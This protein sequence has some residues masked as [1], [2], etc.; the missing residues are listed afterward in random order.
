MEPRRVRIAVG[1]APSHWGESHL[2]SL[3]H[4]LARSPADTVY[5]GETA[6]PADSSLSADFYCRICDELARA[7]KKVYASSLILVTEKDDR[8]PFDRLAHR[9]GR[10]E[11][12]SPAF[13]AAARRYHA[14]AG[15]FLNVYNAAAADIL[16]RCNVERVVLPCD[17]DIESIAAITKRCGIATEVVVHGHVPLAMSPTCLTV[18]VLGRV[19]QAFSPPEAGRPP[20]NQQPGKAAP[21]CGALCRRYP[22]GMIMNAGCRP[23][24]RI[25]GPQTLSAPAW[26]LVE[27]LPELERAGVHTI[28]ILP[29]WR[30]SGRILRI[31][32][33][34]LDRRRTPRDALN[35]LKELSPGG[36]CNGLSVGKAGWIYES[37]N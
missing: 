5:L 22:E 10:V 12:N 13:L 17:L 4:E 1:P 14:V 8:G 31:Y 26:C 16:A 23:L 35:E 6:C 30:H 33:D 19:G 20:I 37:P 9:L 25:D 27:H 3:Y 11:I 29:Q 24:F 18:R 28:R 36:L 34:V 15:A 32:R 2:D 21:Q 7:G